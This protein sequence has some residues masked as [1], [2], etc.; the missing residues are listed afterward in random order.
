MK[1][2]IFGGDKR[3]EQVI[4][5]LE[6]KNDVDNVTAT[7][8]I[9][10][11]IYDV[12]IFPVLGVDDNYQV[13]GNLLGKDFLT[14]TKEGVLIFSGVETTSLK[15]MLTL[16]NKECFYLMKENDVVKQNVIPTVEGIIAD[17]IQNTDITINKANTMVIGYG[18]VGRHLVDILE[19]LGANICVG[20][21]D[22]N[23]YE[24]LKANHKKVFF[25]NNSLMN[26][27]LRVS[28]III[29]TASSLVLKK[30]HIPHLK[31]DTYILDISS[32]PYGIDQNAMK[33]NNINYKI[34]PAIPSKVAPKTSGMI[35][36]RKIN[37]KIGG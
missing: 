36:A 17:V 4:K 16:A 6:K 7:T 33:E 25:T 11:S 19:K 35:L 27:Y 15:N 37:S 22:K 28:D 8:E 12:I 24:Y 21:K 3:Y 30:E 1:V 13:A 20:I 23:D 29:N 26:A 31:K 18:N 5:L 34:Y 2:L 14:K 32:K 9:D 10:Q